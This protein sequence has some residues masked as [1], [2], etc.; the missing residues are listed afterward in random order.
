[1]SEYGRRS[2][3]LEV[4]EVVSKDEI[5]RGCWCQDGQ[6]IGGGKLRW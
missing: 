1:M 2:F 3:G 5:W 4:K 6:W